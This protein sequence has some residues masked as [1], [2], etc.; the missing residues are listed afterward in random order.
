MYRPQIEMGKPLYSGI[1]TFMHLPHVQTL[2]KVDYA[3]IGVPFDTGVSYAIGARFGPSSIRTM[4]QR[5]RPISPVHK[6]D[7]SEYLSGIDY[8]DLRVYPGYIEQSYKIIEEQLT[9]VFEA[10]IVPIMLGGD[11]SIS[12]PHLRAAAKKYGP[13]CLVHFDSHSDTGRAQDPARMWSHGCVFSYA[14]DEGLIDAE[15]SIQMG[16]RGSTFKPNGLDEA[17]AMG[18]EVLT[19]DDVRELTIEELCA[20]V[21]SKVGD[22]PV[23]LTFDIDFLDPTYAPGTGTPEVGGF[24]TYEA[25]RMLRGLAGIN[26]IGFDLVEVLPDRDPSHITAL[27]AANIAF[28]FVCLLAVKRRMDGTPSKGLAVP[29]GT[30]R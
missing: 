22:R 8:G 20:K 29:A 9:P 27:H 3:V 1:H 5:I 21:K 24:T 15:H 26:F 18:F 30:I 25:Q 11:H 14:V 4:S 10:G 23:F 17:R 6:I 2:E 16:M 19:T 28:E 13:V 12:L 7:T